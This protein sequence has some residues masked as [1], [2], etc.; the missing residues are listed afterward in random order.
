MDDDSPYLRIGHMKR[1][2]ILMIII[3]FLFNEDLIFPTRMSPYAH[4]LSQS[5]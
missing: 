3:V 4:F 1:C 2:M 5:S